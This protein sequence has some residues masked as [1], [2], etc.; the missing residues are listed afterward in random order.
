MFIFH[1]GAPIV[2]RAPGALVDGID[3]VTGGIEKMGL[4]ASPPI[5]ADFQIM[6]APEPPAYGPLYGKDGMAVI[7]KQLRWNGIKQACV[8]SFQS[9][10]NILHDFSS[11]R[12]GRRREGRMLMR[13]PL[14]SGL[15]MPS[16]LTE[17]A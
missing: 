5:G 11:L 4:K 10:C 16:P 12:N 2:R 17:T 13:N 7:L 14:S 6:I 3:A 8:K 1:S 9:G 15:R